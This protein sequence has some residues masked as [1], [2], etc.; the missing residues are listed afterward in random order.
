M[1]KAL[2]VNIFCLRNLLTC[3]SIWKSQNLFK[4]VQYNPLIKNLPGQISTMIVTA[5]IIQQEP[6]CLRVSSQQ[7]RALTIAEK[8]LDRLTNESKIC[9]IHGPGR[10][11]DESKV[12]GEFGAKQDKGNPTKDCRNHPVPVKN[13]LGIRKK[14]ILPIMLWMKYYLINHKK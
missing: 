8:N 6:P 5:V 3:L 1:Y 7:E 13:V 10:S 2:V 11:S 12:L 4:K 9:L 14:M